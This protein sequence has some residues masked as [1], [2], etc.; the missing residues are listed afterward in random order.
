MAAPADSIGYGGAL[1]TG[2][3]VES[4]GALRPLDARSRW[5]VLALVAVGLALLVSAIVDWLEIDLMNRVVAGRQVTIG[6]LHASDTRQSIATA[7]YLLGL[8]I[9][10]VFFIRWFHAAYANLG[11]LG[12][13][14]LRFKP[15]WAIGSWFVPILNLV[16]PK[17]I[18]NDIW[19]GS[20]EAAPSYFAAGWKDVAAPQL[21]AWWWAAWLG[22]GFLSNIGARAFDTKTA[23]NI[24]NADWLDLVASVIGIVGVALA[25]V[26][27]RR[28]TERQTLRAQRLAEVGAPLAA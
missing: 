21:L 20:D 17:Q 11:P 28:V 22:S 8:V 13:K 10:A 7:A 16:R 18:A 19:S 23:E 26:I 25:I 4:V 12:Q 9:A 6:D 2:M 24:R 5:A 3:D 1:S 15:G 27:V 14:D